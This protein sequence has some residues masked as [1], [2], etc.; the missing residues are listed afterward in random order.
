VKTSLFIVAAM[1]A[2][3]AAGHAAQ[4]PS[5][6]KAATEKRPV[7]DSYHGIKVID[8]YRWLENWDDPAVKQWSGAENMASRAG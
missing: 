2:A 3:V 5:A 1:A 6:V 7:T 4:A 8:D